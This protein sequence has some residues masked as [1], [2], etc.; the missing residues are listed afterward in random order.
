MH[1]FIK[2]F[3]FIALI[4][5]FSVNDVR[6]ETFPV[7][8]NPV[9]LKECGD[10]HM[11]YPAETLSQKAWENIMSNLS[12][13]FGEDASID[14][15]SA[16][17]VLDFY[18]RNSFDVSKTRAAQKWRT[19]SNVIR[20]TE[21]PRFM[22]KHGNCPAE[23]WQHKNVTSKANCLACH[24]TMNKDGSTRAGTSFLPANLQSQCGDD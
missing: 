16:A 22:K 1:M 14:A 11:V 18:K 8:N 2:I 17:E 12:N 10:C 23:V 15:S 24:K 19:Q 7:I 3:T 9:V 4:T 13:H 21:A 6:A 20:I 5:V